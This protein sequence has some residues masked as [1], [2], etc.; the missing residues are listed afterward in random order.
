MVLGKHCLQLHLWRDVCHQTAGINLSPGENAAGLQIIGRKGTLP[1]L[2]GLSFQSWKIHKTAASIFLTSVHFRTESC[3]VLDHDKI[4]QLLVSQSLTV[5]Y[6][7]KFFL[8][9]SPLS[10]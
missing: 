1:G 8:G 5:I 3:F 6:D 10:W 9:F 4:R 7:A 2:W